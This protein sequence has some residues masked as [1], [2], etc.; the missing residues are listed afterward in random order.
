MRDQCAAGCR[1]CPP[2]VHRQHR[3]CLPPSSMPH[4]PRNRPCLAPGSDSLATRRQAWTS[5]QCAVP[6]CSPPVAHRGTPAPPPSGDAAF[7]HWRAAPA[8][9][10][11]RCGRSSAPTPINPPLRP[12]AA[13]GRRPPRRG[14][15]RTT[16][17]CARYTCAFA[18]CTSRCCLGSVCGAVCGAGC[19][20]AGRGPPNSI[21]G[22]PAQGERGG[23]GTVGERRGSAHTST[24][25]A[26]GGLG[27]RGGGVGA[28]GGRGSPAAGWAS[29]SAR[30]VQVCAGAGVRA[31]VCAALAQATA[32]RENILRG[33][34]RIIMRYSC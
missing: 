34:W 33:G 16:R 14:T 6:A 31:G 9:S 27:G 2:P 21:T 10:P 30:E 29:V 4:H 25:Q 8:P 17:P 3:A 19:T 18:P 32:C 11:R 26:L 5:V 22:W 1:R 24:R 13:A 15:C 7:R 28:G 12:A 23:G 20:A